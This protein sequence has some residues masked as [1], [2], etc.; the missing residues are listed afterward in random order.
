M[1]T[2]E[3]K[4][5]FVTL[6]YNHSGCLVTARSDNDWFKINYQGYTDRQIKGRIKHQIDYRVENNIQQGV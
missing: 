4:E 5:Y 6:D 1:R 2:F 3:H